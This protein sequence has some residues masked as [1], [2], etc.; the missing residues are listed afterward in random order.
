VKTLAD[1]RRRA[2]EGARLEVTGQTKRPELVGTVRTIAHATSGPR[3]TFTSDHDPLCA[4]YHGTW[5]KAGETRIIDADTFEYD[6]HPGPGVIRLR[7]LSAGENTLSGHYHDATGHED[8]VCNCPS[9][10]TYAPQWD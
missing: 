3:Y 6:L 1:I 4:V 2:V 9:P 5:P 7:F 8:T 10:L